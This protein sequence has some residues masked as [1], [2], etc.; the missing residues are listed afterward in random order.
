MTNPLFEQFSQ[1]TP[2]NR[3]YALTDKLAHC[4]NTKTLRKEYLNYI[5]N[6]DAVIGTAYRNAMNFL[7]MEDQTLENIAELSLIFIHMH[8]KDVSP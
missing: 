6:N 5:L 1:I 4:L 7:R 3:D 2:E 8:I